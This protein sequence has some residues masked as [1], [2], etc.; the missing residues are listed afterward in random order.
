MSD[1][2]I[3]AIVTFSMQQDGFQFLGI[4]NTIKGPIEEADMG[5]VWGNF[6]K[7]GGFDRI[8]PYKKAPYGSMVVYY[9][10]DSGDLVYFIGSIVAGVNDPPE[11]YTLASFPG[12]EYLVVTHEW[13]STQEGAINQ[14]SNVNDHQKTVEIPEGYCRCDQSTGRVVLVER[15][16]MHTDKGS[17]YEF[18]VPIQRR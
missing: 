5:M 4:E 18:W 1:N 11:G 2:Q 13:L 14:I 17:R 10:N 6:F 9:R 15:E 12:G 3:A 8:D 16:N 7:A